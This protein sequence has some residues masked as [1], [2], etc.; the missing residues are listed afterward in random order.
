MVEY[1]VNELN[2]NTL[3]NEINFNNSTVGSNT[4]NPIR[5][6]LLTKTKDQFG[7]QSSWQIG[8]SN[9]NGITEMALQEIK[10]LYPNKIINL[11]GLYLT[12]TDV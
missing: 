3:A 4:G 10:K 8:K 11:N 2:L 9:S 7:N 1:N 6:A 5:L 12:L